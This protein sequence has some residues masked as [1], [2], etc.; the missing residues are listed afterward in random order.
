MAL[1]RSNGLWHTFHD[2]FDE[3]M[4]VCEIPE[5][6]IEWLREWKDGKPSFIISE[7]TGIEM[8]KVRD[9]I[10]IVFVRL[11]KHLGIPKSG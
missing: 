1:D 8:A 5:T 4:E 10:M 3:V 2:Q 7:E 11:R 9:G 6:N